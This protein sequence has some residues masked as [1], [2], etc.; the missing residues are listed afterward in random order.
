MVWQVLGEHG[1]MRWERRGGALISDSGTAVFSEQGTVLLKFEIYTG[2][3]QGNF[4]WRSH[5]GM[6]LCCHV[7]SAIEWQEGG[8]WGVREG[9]VTAG[10]NVGSNLHR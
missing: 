7:A 1:R 3:D 6:A 8:F 5:C 9:P 4:E 2:L 10:L